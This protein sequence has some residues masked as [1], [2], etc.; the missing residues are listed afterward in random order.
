MDATHSIDP[1]L[2]W[3]GALV[4]LL[5][6]GT[7]IWNIFS[8]PAKRAEVRVTELAKHID[9]NDL[10]L[11]RIEDRIAQIPTVQALHELEM[12]LQRSMGEIGLLNERLKPVAAIAERMQE[13]MLEN[14]K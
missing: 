5:S 6:F 2:F 12:S 10:R 11:Q 9:G 4:L 13:W 1:I 7:T 3:V 14:G 8:S